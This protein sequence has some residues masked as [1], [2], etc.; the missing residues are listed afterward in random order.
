MLGNIY[1]NL[2]LYKQEGSFSFILDSDELLDINVGYYS[3]PYFSDLDL[4]GD[5]DLIVGGQDRHRV[6]L[7]DSNLFS[8]VNDI[9]IPYLGKNVKFSGGNLFNSNQFDIISGIS[10]GGVYFLSEQLCDQGD[11][12][13]DEVIDIFDML[14]LIQLVLELQ[15][16]NSY[17]K[18]SGDIDNNF[19]FNILDI[20]NLVDII[21]GE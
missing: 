21:L 9:E 18:C 14:I 1:G 15:D 8:E 6:Y 13:Q 12:N 17:F 11:L 20:L 4:D 2:R 7:N 3:S 10:T 16:K 19:G 5:D